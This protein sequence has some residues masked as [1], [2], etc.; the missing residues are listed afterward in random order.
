MKLDKKNMIKLAIVTI[1]AI[2]I[3]LVAIIPINSKYEKKGSS[4]SQSST[5]SI[6]NYLI[7]SCTLN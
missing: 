2:I 5:P 6:F 4:L 1:V 3:A 7:L